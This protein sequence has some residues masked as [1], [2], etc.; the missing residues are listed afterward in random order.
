MLN[1]LI[2]VLM[3]TALSKTKSCPAHTSSPDA[4]E[5][6]AHGAL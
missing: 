6:G 2:T 4:R 3:N 5:S 1:T